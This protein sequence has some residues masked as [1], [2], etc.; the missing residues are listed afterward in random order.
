MNI[1]EYGEK[2]KEIR[3]KKGLTQMELAEQCHIG[4][5]TIQRIENGKVSPRIQTVKILNDFLEIELSDFSE[6]KGSSLNYRTIFYSGISVFCLGIMFTVAVHLVMGI[7][8]IIIG[9]VN[10]VL[11]LRN[12][13]FKF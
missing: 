1:K 8:F 2:I 7:A 12:S 10:I 9:A 13:E 4:I 6:L 5:R 3:T 11:G